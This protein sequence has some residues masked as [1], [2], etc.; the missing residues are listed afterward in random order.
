MPEETE[1][2]AEPLLTAGKL[3]AW[4][5]AQ[6]KLPPPRLTDA[7]VLTHQGILLPRRS[8]WQRAG[9]TRLF[10][11]DA[12]PIGGGTVTLASV[13]GVGAPATAVAVEELAAAGVRQLIAL[14][15]CGSIDAS[16][17]SGNVLLVDQAIACDGTSPHYTAKPHIHPN[18]RLTRRLGGRLATAGVPFRSGAV[19]S[20]DAVYRETPAMLGDALRQ[21]AVA[22][23][24][25]TACVLAVAE[26][27]GIE[28]A[29][30]LV[31]VDELHEGWR[32]PADM[33]R[34][35]A[36]LRHLLDEAVACLQP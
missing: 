12:R 16:L 30:V 14:D 7:A 6:A 19:L 25:E 23:D 18:D 11:F 4:R 22:I 9:A 2:H 29:V 13:R 31:A 10:S 1:A 24:M 35:H 3:L 28:A 15:V 8:P 5:S 20:T 36:R 27:V 33:G 34:V 17:M 26:V 21:G 32:P